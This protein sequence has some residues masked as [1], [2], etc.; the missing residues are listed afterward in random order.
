MAS[1]DLALLNPWWEDPAALAREP[2]HHR[3]LFGEVV[4]HLERREVPVGMLVV[5]PRRVGK[6]VL[7]RQAL[8]HFLRQGLPPR[9]LVLADFQGLLLLQVS[10][11]DVIDA[12]VR[13]ADAKYPV[14][15]ILDEIQYVASWDRAL[16]GALQRVPDRVRILATGSCAIELKRSARDLL[17]DRIALREMG[18]MTFREFVALQGKDPAGPEVLQLFQRFLTRGGFPGLVLEESEP[19]IAQRLR[20]MCEGQV[21]QGD[22]VR[23]LGVRNSHLLGRLWLHVVRNP[24]EPLQ[25]ARLAGAIGTARETVDQWIHGLGMAELIVTVPPSDRAGRPTLGRNRHDRIYPID[26]ALS[27]A[28]GVPAS[29]DKGLET[30]VLRHL[31]QLCEHLQRAG[32]G[33]TDLTYWRDDKAS[34]P[35]EIDFR[36]KT[37]DLDLLVE[38]KGTRDPSSRYPSRLASIARRLGVGQAVLVYGGTDR[39]VS[40][41]EGVKV[42]VWPVHAFALATG[43]AAATGQE[44][45]RD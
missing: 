8:Q 37:D 28:Y 32:R 43:D 40:D 6:T 38:V 27:A 3:G 36:L 1:P 34:G 31:R 41:H 19:T 22:L 23:R 2:L 16:R 24:G 18:P 21:I 14:L 4:A 33:R 25:L 13:R 30:L 39:R 29:E 7:A 12:A 10:V 9:N 11:Q 35:N 15:V 26:H 45:F 17:L 5:G 20:D 42:H 44:L